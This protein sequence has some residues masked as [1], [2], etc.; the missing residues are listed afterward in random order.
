MCIFYDLYKGYFWLG[1]GTQRSVTEASSQRHASQLSVITT[2]VE[3]CCIQEGT[4]QLK[5]LSILV[6]WE[7]PGQ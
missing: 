3:L 2:F 6:S 1:N 4:H 5:V 7:H